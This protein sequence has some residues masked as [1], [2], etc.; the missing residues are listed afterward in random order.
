DQLARCL[1]YSFFFF[2]SRRRHTR[3]SRDWSSDV[4]SSDLFPHEPH[5][6][7]PHRTAAHLERFGEGGHAQLRARRQLTTEDHL[8]QPVGDRVGDPRARRVVHSHHAGDFTCTESNLHS[9]RG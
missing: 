6:R 1:S 3:F 4:C 5:H 9:T 7:V 2:S 8:A